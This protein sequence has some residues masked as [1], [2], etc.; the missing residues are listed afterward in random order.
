LTR[1]TKEVLDLLGLD[2]LYMTE[3]KDPDNM[4]VL[5]QAL[6]NLGLLT[7][8]FRS[9]SREVLA[10][11][12]RKH[13]FDFE[14]A[15]DDL[16]RAMAPDPSPASIPGQW[17]LHDRFTGGEPW[18]GPF[19]DPPEMEEFMEGLRDL[20]LKDK[21]GRPFCEEV[22]AAA[23]RVAFHDPIEAAD[24]LIIAA[25]MLHRNSRYGT[26]EE[27][28]AVYTKLRKRFTGNYWYSGRRMKE[29]WHVAPGD[30]LPVVP[31]Y[32]HISK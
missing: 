1:E 7:H 9:F 18:N 29:P 16:E 27:K 21:R 13:S 10:A 30:P 3:V 4:A 19:D 14:Q 12:L 5:I 15:A 11:L 26:L 32:W 17:L 2:E 25:D 24:Q 20:G 6:Q 22:L 28:R 31:E 8:R 23:L